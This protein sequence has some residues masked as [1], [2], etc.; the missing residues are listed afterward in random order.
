MPSYPSLRYF[1][2]FVDAGE[3]PDPFKETSY[4][5]ELLYRMQIGLVPFIDWA[6]RSCSRVR[7]SSGLMDCIVLG[8]KEVEGYDYDIVGHYR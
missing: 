5:G 8:R 6:P 1:R 4:S 2:R 3:S 7:F